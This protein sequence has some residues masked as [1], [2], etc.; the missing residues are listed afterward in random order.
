[1]IEEGVV[2]GSKSEGLDMAGSDLDI[3]LCSH[4][5]HEK[6]DN[7]SNTISDYEYDSLMNN[8]QPGYVMLKT[9]GN[10]AIVLPSNAFNSQMEAMRNNK[11]LRDILKT[12]IHGPAV[13]K[14]VNGEEFDFV[15][16][17]K[18]ESWPNIAMEWIN[19]KRKF[20]WPSQKMVHSIVKKGCNIV[21]VG[22][23]R[24]HESDEDWRL[25]FCMAEQELIETF[26][27]SQLI[28]YGALKL[29]L[30]E[31]LDKDND[32]H[33][34]CSYFLKTIMFWVVEETSS[35]NWIPQNL[36]LCF[37]MCI[38]RLIKFVKEENC[39]NYFVISNNIFHERINSSNKE[40][41]L[42][43]L[44]NIA[45]NGWQWMMETQTL[46]RY[47]YFISGET[48]KMKEK[49]KEEIS[50][51]EQ[52]DIFNLV[53]QIV[54]RYRQH[55]C[56]IMSRVS[57][58]NK[59]LLS[60]M[61]KVPLIRQKTLPVLC[62]YID[63]DSQN[64]G[65]K[66][67]YTLRKLHMQFLVMAST[68]DILCGK[69]LLASWLYQQGKHNECL[70]VTDICLQNLDLGI[71]HENKRIMKTEL[72]EVICTNDI[73]NIQYLSS[74]DLMFPFESSI[75]V[76]ELAEIFGRNSTKIFYQYKTPITYY[77]PRN[78]MYFLRCLC[79]FKLGDAVKCEYAYTEM[80]S[81][82]ERYCESFKLLHS[83]NNFILKL[84]CNKIRHNITFDFNDCFEAANVLNQHID[85]FDIADNHRSDFCN[86]TIKL[87]ETLGLNNGAIMDIVCAKLNQSNCD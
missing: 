24:N 57:P 81:V 20:R 44:Y 53:Y 18:S 63:T 49:L 64:L 13:M 22:S 29:V 35:S 17:V 51:K 72:Y 41:L 40:N 26:N 86:N 55:I 43:V 67:L 83:F 42:R 52:L 32:A 4:R 3:L 48:N 2:I 80:N 8:I 9:K 85:E 66:A 60:T 78:Y 1:M 46:K 50:Q 31:I 36:L 56:F 58:M 73:P 68:D 10:T 28:V 34:I 16:S 45:N 61:C 77:C 70:N 74:S 7:S 23:S 62:H 87:L 47:P 27:H 5:A 37:Q 25:S 84:A 6:G 19:R 21:P 76:R 79:Y 30:K 15:I 65:N 11:P 82:C 39:P 12:E 75:I 14:S 71:M 33:L 38:R 54:F 69:V 59:H